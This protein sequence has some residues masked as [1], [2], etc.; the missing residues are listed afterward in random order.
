M[1]AVLFEGGVKIVFWA[2]DQRKNQ[3]A[4]DRAEG[5]QYALK[6]VRPKLTKDEYDAAIKRLEREFG[7]NGKN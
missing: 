5:A 2:I 1:I 3:R 4:R 7:V 6:L